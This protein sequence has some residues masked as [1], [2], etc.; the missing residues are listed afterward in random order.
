MYSYVASIVD[1]SS[2]VSSIRAYGQQTRFMTEM[3][4]RVDDNQVAYYPIICADRCIY[5]QCVTASFYNIV[6]LRWLGIRLEFIGNLVILFA[7]LFAVIQRNS[8]SNIDPGLAGLSISYALQ[9]TKYH[10]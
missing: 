10:R 6:L 4:H 1:Y 7:A 2:G 8:G 9:V 3:K 5:F